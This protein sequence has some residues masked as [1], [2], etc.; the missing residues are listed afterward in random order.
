[1]QVINNSIVNKDNNI[2][3]NN[4]NIDEYNI[5]YIRTAECGYK[6]YLEK[7]EKTKYEKFL[8]KGCC[9][10]GNNKM[11]I[12]LLVYS[13]I[14]IIFTILGIFFKIS[15]NEGYKEYKSE[16]EK[17]L[18]LIDTNLPDD[19]EMQRII[20]YTRIIKE[21]SYNPF[22]C[23]YE[24]FRLGICKW[25]SYKLYCD[26]EK[27]FN[28]K[29]NL[30]DYY[31]YYTEEFF[32]TYE[33]YSK[34]YCSYQQYIDYTSGYFKEFI[35]YGGKPKRFIIETSYEVKYEDFRIF[36][37]YFLHGTSFLQFW[38]N[39]GKYDNPLLISLFIVMITFITLL[40]V[41]LYIKKDIISIG[42]LYYSILILYMIFDIVFR[43]F[44][45]LLFCLL[46]YAVVVTASNPEFEVRAWSSFIYYHSQSK[47]SK[48]TIP[49]WEDKRIYAI[50][51]SV[52][53]FFLFIF[54]VY[55][56]IGLKVVIINYLGINYEGNKNYDKI[57]RKI[58]IRLGR[59]IYEIEV[60]NKKDVYLYDKITRKKI[61]FKEI[62]F[63]KLGED[64]YYLKL[65]NK[66]LVDQLGFSEWNYPDIN[67][68]FKRLGVISDLTYVLL[69]FSVILIK[70]QINQEYSYRFLKY[71]I[72]LGFSFRYSGYVENFGALEKA[73]T[74][75]RL[76]CY[77]IVYIVILITKLKRAFFGGIKKNFIFLIFFIVLILFIV[78][79][80][81][82]LILTIIIDIYCWIL[83]D[84]DL[85]SIFIHE[86]NIVFPKIIVQVGLN[87]IILV[88]QIILLWK[89][90]S[91]TRFIF[92]MKTENDK[93]GSENQDDIYNRDEGFE[94]EGKD[95]RNYYFQAINNTKFPQNLFYIKTENKK[96]QILIPENENTIK[97]SRQGLNIMNNNINQNISNNSKDIYQTERLKL[98][99][100]LVYGIAS[101][102][103]ENIIK[104]NNDNN[105]VSIKIKQNENISQKSQN[106]EIY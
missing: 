16:I 34:N 6:D 26:K 43:I 77:T 36:Y 53:I 72:E 102:D 21:S 88:I 97:Q 67:E 22:N 44:I 42:V 47:Y 87:I 39:I 30:V 62:K 64:N 90:I 2:H 25:D 51:A 86:E 18:N 28:D 54:V 69:F 99:Y 60:K 13:F 19:S 35:Y 32:C 23:S 73:I 76:C 83:I 65:S 1:M 66:S 20:N 104:Q 56:L 92:T 89:N 46:L 61:K 96:R 59:E 29:C 27:Y 7:K 98:N 80:L 74:Y 17:A 5:N 85:T 94:F 78:F 14:I 101:K 55:I 12:T 33:D 58:S 57:K 79:N 48:I 91:Y 70:F 75:Y 49:L 100:N 9:G 31:V 41:D 11:T 68:G 24:M 81:V 3:D 95:K 8:N 4:K 38:C 40:I 15:N 103:R 106:D 50:V 105:E 84:V 37:F 52:I 71:A 93:I 63:D 45:I 82:S 10:S